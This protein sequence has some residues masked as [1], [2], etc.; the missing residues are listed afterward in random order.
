MLLQCE[1]RIILK[2]LSS[3][4]EWGFSLEFNGKDRGDVKFP[5]GTACRSAVVGRLGL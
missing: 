1:N 2:G 4:G 3:R 5:A